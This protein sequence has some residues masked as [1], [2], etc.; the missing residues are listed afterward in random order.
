MVHIMNAA[1]PVY[2]QIKQTVKNWIINKEFKP[3]DKIPSANEL[4]TQFKVSRLTVHQALS[5][6]IQEGFL[7]SKRGEGTFV[8]MDESIISS[9]GLEFSG[10]M[11]DL[12]YQVQ[13]SKTKSV[14]IAKVT[15]PKLIR[16]KLELDDENT[17]IV[18]INRVRFKGRR[19]FAYTVNHLP[20]SIG[21]KINLQLSLI[22]LQILLK[23]DTS[24]GAQI[25][26]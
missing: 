21:E 4:A 24:N 15:A 3:G 2:Y 7:I 20:I 8:T 13:K 10:F 5:Q 18:Q 22:L 1:L 23:V 25:P 11:D 14:K 6:L 26:H 19:P 9:F 12:F 17:E 16:E